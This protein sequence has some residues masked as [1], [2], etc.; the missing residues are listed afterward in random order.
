MI[1]ILNDEDFVKKAKLINN[2]QMIANS[3]K[4]QIKLEI[5]DNNEDDEEIE[6]NSTEFI[7]LN[8]EIAEEV[9]K[10]LPQLIYLGTGKLIKIIA[11]QHF[12]I[13][14]LGNDCIFAEENIEKYQIFLMNLEKFKSING[15]LLNE[16]DFRNLFRRWEMK[17]NYINY[18][19]DYLCWIDNENYLILE[20]LDVE[21]KLITKKSIVLI[22]TLN[23]LFLDNW[24]YDNSTNVLTMI[25]KNYTDLLRFFIMFYIKM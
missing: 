22:E 21:V 17:I 2:F 16:N 11:A 14:C 4:Q 3:L 13:I 10:K 23:D 12:D 1:V 8:F 9:I 20:N 24:N 6:E 5:F 7:N 15:I 19:D 18:K 25:V